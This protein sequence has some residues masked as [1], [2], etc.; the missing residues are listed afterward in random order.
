MCILIHHTATTKFDRAILTDFYDHN[1]DGFGVMWGDG[2][3]VHVIKSLGTPADIEAIY[4]DHI[5][6]RECIIH[7]RMKTHGDID[8]ENCHPYRITDD[9]WLAHNGVLSTGNSADTSKSDTW[10]Y[11]KNFLRPIVE[12]YGADILFEDSMQ[13]YI[14]SHI[15]SN[16]KFGIVH[17]D[18]RIA[19]INRS[20]GVEHFGAWLSNT[21][22]WSTT[23]FGYRDKYDYGYS[24][25]YPKSYGSRYTGSLWHQGGKT[26]DDDGFEVVASGYK[27][28]PDFG[29]YTDAE[30]D[31]ITKA[32]Y[33]CYVRGMPA[34]RNWVYQAPTKAKTFLLSWMDDLAYGEAEQL[35]DSSPDEAAEMIAGLFEDGAY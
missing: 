24:Y 13:K 4:N 25:G 8:F 12:K 28:D 5:K 7:F 30:V 1:S 26:Y 10:H 15:G 22:A 32:A 27:D 18:G 9:V 23:K 21:Y 34:L 31:R 35:V 20:A 2:D 17:K 11:I 6:G 19:T 3:K 16:N 29:D 33:N 14:G